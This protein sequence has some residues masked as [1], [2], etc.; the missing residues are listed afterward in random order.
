MSPN[1]YDRLGRTTVV[2]LPDP[3]G[4]GS[5]LAAQTVSEYDAY[6]DSIKTK[7]RLQQA[8]GGVTELVTQYAFDRLGRVVS[9]TD[10]RN[11][12]T[13]FG[14]DKL[15]NRTRV[16]DPLNNDTTF[17]YDNLNRLKQEQNELGY[18][19]T[20]AYDAVNNLTSR[21]DRN[22]RTVSYGY[23]YLDRRTSETFGSSYTAD[24]KSVV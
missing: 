7:E 19:R 21:T 13:G 23:D 24:R 20:Y 8:G 6:G 12:V 1:T 17:T 2:T 22:G 15:G 18:S 4:A 10:P 16:T 11:A 14:Y 3:G 9:T 5:Q